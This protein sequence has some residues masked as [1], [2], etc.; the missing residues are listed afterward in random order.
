MNNNSIYTIIQDTREQNGYNF[1]SEQTCSGTIEKKLDTGDYSI[2]GLED[3]IC[4]ERKASVEELAINL[5]YKQEAFLKEIK[6]METF[7]YKF[8]ILEFSLEDLIDFPERT[9]IPQ[10][11]K[12]LIKMTGKYILK[13]LMEFQ[14]Y[15]N[16]HIM[17]CGNRKS[18]S[19]A[20]RSLL[21]RLNALYT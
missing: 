5:G 21:K 2:L 16:L 1:S 14:I 13:C 3:Q 4:I 10:D 9:K 12:V 11:K 18:A 19:E 7:K 15:N 20:V 8:L 17:F 6:R